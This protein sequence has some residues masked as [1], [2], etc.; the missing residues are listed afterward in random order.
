MTKEARG[1]DGGLK[2]KGHEQSRRDQHRP[3]FLIVYVRKINTS[4][5]IRLMFH[6]FNM[7][8]N[9]STL[10]TYDFCQIDNG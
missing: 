9:W 4:L 5:N 8:S 7:Q 3:R 6:R 10:I 2:M 1:I